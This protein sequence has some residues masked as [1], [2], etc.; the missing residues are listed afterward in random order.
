LNSGLNVLFL[1]ILREESPPP[2]LS[3]S[4]PEAPFF[5][6]FRE[7]PFNLT[8]VP[9]NLHS[10]VRHPVISFPL[11]SHPRRLHT[12]GP[13]LCAPPPHEIPF[14]SLSVQIPFTIIPFTGCRSFLP[15][16]PHAPSSAIVAIPRHFHFPICLQTDA[17]LLQLY[18]FYRCVVPPLPAFSLT[19]DEWLPRLASSGHLTPLFFPSFARRQNALFFLPLPPFSRPCAVQV[20]PSLPLT[21]S[22][23]SL[24]FPSLFYPPS[25]HCPGQLGQAFLPLLFGTGLPDSLFCPSSLFPLFFFFVVCP[26]P[27]RQRFER[28]QQ[29]HLLFFSRLTFA[30]SGEL[31]PT[32]T[33]RRPPLFP[34]S[35]PPVFF[36]SSP[37]QTSLLGDLPFAVFY[38]LKS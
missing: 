3:S 4:S 37:P 23:L 27:P 13:P 33:C 35:L 29:L 5:R 2:L 25:S 15:Y 26:F 14:L 1:P 12:R 31:F 36:S 19:A 38:G 7:C 21:I 11:T 24:A 16:P 8:F 18:V 9:G 30:N 28:F 10:S 17:L 20:L 34:L 32:S 22:T 6:L